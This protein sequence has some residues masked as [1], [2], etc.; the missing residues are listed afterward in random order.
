MTKCP[1]NPHCRRYEIRDGRKLAAVPP[2]NHAR[3]YTRTLFSHFPL[4]FP[5]GEAQHRPLP[6]P[7]DAGAAAVRRGRGPGSAPPPPLGGDVQ[8]LGGPWRPGGGGC[9]RGRGQGRGQ[10]AAPCWWPCW[11]YWRCAAR[12]RRRRTRGRLGSA[13]TSSATTTPEDRSTPGRRRACPS[14]TTRC[15]SARPRVGAGPAGGGGGGKEGARSRERLWGAAGPPRQAERPGRG[16]PCPGSR[17][18]H[19]V[20]RPAALSWHG[21]G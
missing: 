10:G 6:A 11:R 19:F 13:G 18:E 9:G 16:A 14:P 17:R 4:F 7:H 3:D 5:S 2:C 20:S 21:E 12:P 8:R 15:T 1:Q